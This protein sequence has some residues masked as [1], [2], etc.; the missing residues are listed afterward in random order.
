MLTLHVEAATSEEL[1][2]KACAALGLRFAGTVNAAPA[3]TAAAQAQSPTVASPTPPATAPAAA[4][5]PPK[6]GRPRKAAPAPEARDGGKPSVSESQAQVDNSASEGGGTPSAAT[7]P[8]E[9]PQPSST[10]ATAAAS[11]VTFDDMKAKLQAVAAKRPGD[12]DDNDGLARA[13]S[14]IGK[15]GYRKIKEV[16]PEHFVAIVADCEAVK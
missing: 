3:S 7:S 6:K 1:V 12:K 15:Y 14:I 13:S 16:K 9:A 4:V 2:Q 5:E 11:G 10:P 8:S